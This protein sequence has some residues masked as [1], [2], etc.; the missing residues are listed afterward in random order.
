MDS[1]R[2]PVPQELPV[3]Y[4]EIKITVQINNQN[5]NAVPG[6]TVEATPKALC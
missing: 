3:N 5:A 1:F 6:M 2:I 4:M